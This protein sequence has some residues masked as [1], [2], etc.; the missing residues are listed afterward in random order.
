[1]KNHMSPN[2]W[3][4]HK[5]SFSTSFLPRQSHLIHAIMLT[6][7]LF[8]CGVQSVNAQIPVTV[9]G[10]AVTSPP[11]AASYT[12]LAL[13]LTDLNLVTSYTVPGTI[14]FTCAAGSSET[15]PTT[16]LTLGSAT[17]NPLLSS[18]NTIT[19]I[20]AGGTVTLNAG[21]GVAASPSA[22]P[23]CIMKLTGADYVTIDGLTFT[24][25]NSA[26]A[27]VAMEVGLGL[28]KLNA[29]DG[30]NN[31]TIQNCTFNMQRISNGGGTTPMLDGSWAIEVVNSTATAA[32][33]SLTPTNGGTL[34][35]NGT[36]SGNKFYANSINNGNG[37]IGFGGFAASSGAGPAPTATT[38]LGDLGN[39]VGGSALATG[40]TILNFGG[41]AATSPS[42]GIR[43][44]NQWSINI[45]YNTVNNNNGSGVN[46]T[47]TFRGIYGQAGTSAT[48]T[49]SNNI[50]TLQAGA[51]TSTVS[52]IENV[53]GSTAASNT[54]SINSNTIKIAYT[55]ATTGVING[56]L[57]SSTA[58]T[59]NINSNDIQGVPSTSIAGTGLCIMISAGSSGGT[60]N[61]NSNTISNLNRSGAS[62]TWRGIVGVTPPTVWNCTGNTIDG[63]SWTAAAST[64]SIDGIYNLSSAPVQNINSN[65]IRNLSTPATGTITG[66]RLNTV[67]GTHQ[68]N[69]N[70]IYN[71]STTA[72][73][74]GGATFFGIN[75]SNGVF[76][77]SGNLIYSLNST[78]TTGGTGGTVYGIQITGTTQTLSNN[79][80]YD[81]SSTSTNVTVAGI[82]ITGGTTNNLSNNLIGDL[83]AINS[84]GNISIS[85]ILVGGGTTNNIFHNTVNI[86]STTSS[87][88]TFGTS[89]IYFS[90]STPVNNLRNNIFVNTSTP[91]PTGGFTAAI[92]YTTAPTTTNFPVSN[93]NNFYYGGVAAANKVIYGEGSAAAATNGQLTIAAYKTYISVTLP[94][95]GRESA[96]V[97]EVPNFVSTT[98]SNPITTFLKYNTGIATQ[99]EQGGGVGTGISTDYAGTTRCPGGGC[100]GSASTPD[101]GAWELNG[102][103]LDLSGPAISYTPLGNG[104]APSTNQTLTAT[105][106]DASGV[107][108]SGT[109]LPMLYYKVNMG[110]YIGV[111]GVF[112]SGNT[113]TF[114]FGS[115]AT[116]VGDIVSYYIVAQDG[117]GTPNVSV[118]P[119]AGASGFSTN[120]PAVS[121]PPTNPSTFTVTGSLS[122]EYTVGAAGVYTTL[123]AAIADYNL[124]CISGPVVFN[125]IDATY[126]GSETFP[127][128]INANSTANVTNTLTIKPNSGVTATLSGSVASA[129]LIKFNGADFVT[130]DGSNSGG[131]DRSLTI[132]NTSTTSPS[133][134]SLASLGTGLGATNNI[135]KNCN[136]STGVSTATGYGIAVGGSTP[137]TTGADNDNV[138]IQN[139]NIT[140]ATVSI[141]AAGT[142][143]S[144]TG[145][146]D[147][148]QITNNNVNSNSAL[149]NQGIQVG[150][151]LN[152]G[153]TGNTVSVTSS[154]AVQ[155]VGISIETGFVSSTV[156][157]NTITN[158]LATNGGGYGGRGITVGTG[159]ATSSVTI[160]N[161]VIYGVNGSNWSSFSASSSMGIGIGVLGGG[162][163]TTTTGGVN[164]YF[165]SVNM[166]GSMGTASSTALTTALYIGSG[167]SALNIRDNIFVNTQVGTSTTQKNY[168]IYSAV[169]NTAFTTINNNDYFVSNTFNAASA[170]PGFIG[171]DRV[172]LAGI[173]AGFGS[174]LNSI[175]ADPQFN[176]STNLVLN[177]GSPALAAG[178]NPNN[179]GITTDFLGVARATP[180]SMGAY[181]VGADAAAPTITYSALLGTCSTADRTLTATLAD[182][183]GLATGGNSPR[184]Y[185]KKGIGGT[186][187]SSPGSL[188]TGTVINGTW[189]FTIIAADMGGIASGDA[190]YYY[191]IA[192]DIFGN[193][194][195]NP[196]AGLVA[197]NVN[198]VTTPPTTP[199]TYNI[200]STLAGGTYTVGSGQTYTTLTAA[201]ADYN[202]KCI[203]GPIVFNLMDASYSGSETFPIVINANGDASAVNTLTIKPNAPGTTITGSLASGALIKLNGADYV[204]IDGSTSGGTDQSLTITNSNTTSPAAIW[205]ASS[206]TASGA[207]NNTI[208]N[209]IINTGSNAATSYGIALAGAT[210]GTGGADND[211]NTLQNNTITQCYYGI[212][213]NG[214]SA[215]STGGDD[216]LTIASSTVGP[217]AS[218]TSNIGFTGIWVANALN[219]SIGNNTIQ[220]LVTTVTNAGAIRLDNNVNG[221]TL[222][223]NNIH[224]INSSAIA[225]GT[226]SIC[227]IYLG[228]AVINSPTSVK[229]NV[230]KTIVSTTT[231]GYGSRGIIVNTGNAASAISIYNNMIS[232]VYCYADAS[233]IYWPIGIDIDGTS[234]GINIYHNSIN[235]FG[236]HTG[237]A[238]ASSATASAALFINTS[239]SNIDVRD[240]ILTNSY[241]NS[242]R[243]DDK[244][245]AIYSTGTTNTQFNPVMNYNDFYVSGTPGVLGSINALDRV[246][247]TDIQT[248]FGGNSNSQNIAPLYTASTD[249]HLP[250]ATNATLD[251]L[252]T[253]ITGITTD[254]DNDSRSASTPDIGADEFAAPP[255][256]GAVGGTA[257][258]TGSST[259]CGSGT[260]VITASGYSTGT[261]SGYQ[262]MTS[263]SFSDYPL[264]GTPVSG[265]TNPA[266]LSTGS[267]TVTRYYWLKVTCPTGTMTD[268]STSVLVTINPSSAIISGPA[269][270]CSGDPA[271]N[272]TETG[273][274]GTSWLWSTTETTS[275][276]SVNPGSTTTYTVTVTS[277]GACTAVATKTVTVIPAPS[278]PVV[279]PTTPQ[280][281]CLGTGQALTAFS[282]GGS[283]VT[284]LS[285]DFNST[286]AGTT[287]SG[288]LPA[289]WAGASLTSGIR[290]WG[291]VASA[292]SGS[293][294]GG[295]N[296]LYC[297][298]DAYSSF[299]T[300]SYVTTPT[301]NAAGYS[302]V[303]IRFK[304]YYNDL[305]SGAATDSARVYISNDGGANYTLIQSYDV[306]QGTAFSGA[307]AVNATIPAG[308]SLTNTMKVK[309]VYNS[310]SGGND[311]YWAIDDFVIDGIPPPLYSWTSTP[312]AGSG[313]PGG[314]GTPSQSNTSITA[315]PT[316]AGVYTYS[317]I[318]TSAGCPSAP[319]TTAAITV[320]ASPTIS[321]GSN[322][323][324][325]SCV[326]S[327]N[328]T[329]S[330]TTGSPD[331]YSIDYDAAANTAG[332]TDVVNMALPGSPIVLVVPVA[333]AGTYNAMLTV[334]NSTSTCSSI[335][336]PITVTINPPVVV[337]T[338][339]AGAGSLRDIIGCVPTGSTISFDPSIWNSTIN[340][341]T[342]SILINKNI[343]LSGPTGADIINISANG[344]PP[345]FNITSGN[346]QFTGN[347]Y[348]KQ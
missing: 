85:G 153:V 136:I 220:N 275:S 270:K 337:N 132:T 87:A 26:S 10:T 103:L 121:T 198:S 215:T 165:N 31:N 36:N 142:A 125:L 219:V 324:V 114:T 190:I 1:M 178:E 323:S 330:A 135:I 257:A 338:A 240:N 58:A 97:S 322:P 86:A 131:T 298:S 188:S 9:S 119:S 177:L 154:G 83:R 113:Y 110:A 111:Q 46:H 202:S 251:N 229:N 293:T 78:G 94:A 64:G 218:G 310:D 287:T 244:S 144:T 63:L 297:E 266:S 339:D 331:Q 5:D 296:F 302:S 57:N 68:C 259:F 211:N 279:T 161:N 289:G 173:Q 264:T 253:F 260:P 262:W 115:A 343:T 4:T 140:V 37:G 295:G 228:S 74:A 299:Q 326:T 265:Q 67:T 69:N 107:P 20:K 306:D 213:A 193:V 6:L 72:G 137:G 314:A 14:I 102:L 59:I 277:P 207:T 181:E 263:T 101:M 21:V 196:G 269:T 208:K 307:G 152:S 168:S 141:Y 65:I 35:T 15:A 227:G 23:D 271:V 71:F 62:G 80:I 164:L 223:G 313:L 346:L 184:I 81:L 325:A 206:G 226:S 312:G 42:A 303:N 291:V 55:T 143:S 267:V 122:G 104:C 100:P 304:Q 17:L 18:T 201:V 112:V 329:Y 256:S 175:T 315:T 217:V 108:T 24:D 118:T 48:A 284:I 38:F 224:D 285:D 238:S 172:D 2:L 89:A 222:S 105:I 239:G 166:T 333:L 233:N 294:L 84:T 176:N 54:V 156:T 8:L 194:S 79:A 204:I 3:K 73:G 138:T 195:A 22:S 236:A 30:C 235:L 308:I 340:L 34:A 328:L 106:T 126:S 47:T 212:Y 280:T 261:G 158:V 258:I 146:D 189:L 127:I 157:K 99:I 160:A 40:N 309:L 286:T 180:P 139:N 169:A 45:S 316:V 130:I 16:G 318:A 248:G 319:A 209:C 116:M 317:A 92:R 11:L 191:V 342:G 276:I 344:T 347:V 29:G 91:G 124:K 336:Y 200:Q 28:F 120:P 117:A 50:I 192:Q 75:S 203:S 274:T 109:G 332:F 255:C 246:T 129:A 247:L 128:V 300:R 96:S 12:S 90:S 268:Y 230:I 225:S 197:T 272:L 321:L 76:T 245:Y 98:G 167:T 170:I 185:Y 149:Q 51:T 281:I 250:G 345:V 334:R 341:T 335:S 278:V 41:G 33:T 254:I 210:L 25:G 60:L 145:G 19:I 348:I 53:I 155:P 44:N 174:N 32:T 283:A 186:W 56:I 66:I 273:G 237:Y 162:S 95:S 288:N 77:C 163:L 88:T 187:F 252:G 43:A 52:A 243:T 199:N 242:T 231:S 13:A 7:V 61:T 123:T 27:T 134:V 241:D 216:N 290:I 93:N 249:L 133:A 148:L 311:W 221:F 282:S 232:D 147:N 182:G 82:N 305:T 292:Q 151:A 320:T 179:T 150:N 70:Q 39:D 234:G 49:I 183:S 214:T 159:T 205:M 301:F 171:S 327:A